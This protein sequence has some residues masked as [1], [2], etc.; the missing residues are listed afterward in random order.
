MASPL[1]WRQT[2]FRERR[3]PHSASDSYQGT[4]SEAAEKVEFCRLL[5]GRG[6][7]RA[8]PVHYFCHSP[9]AN[10]VPTKRGFCASW[11]VLQPAGNLLWRSFPQPP[12]AITPFTQPTEQGCECNGLF[13][14][15]ISISL[16]TARQNRSTMCS[17]GMKPVLL[18]R[19]KER[20]PK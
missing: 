11:G 18:K 5:K 7:S 3:I 6:F 12:R 20:W 1:G 14:P 16:E 15:A 9:L 10:G 13:T 2:F 4:T 17:L 8:V 19:R